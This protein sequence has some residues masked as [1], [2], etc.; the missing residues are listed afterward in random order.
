MARGATH[1]SDEARDGCGKRLRRSFPEKR[2]VM[3]TAAE[4]ADPLALL[5]EQNLARIPELV[6]VR[7]G[8]MAASPFCVLPGCRRCHGGRPG[9]HPGDGIEVAAAATPTSQ[10][11]AVRVAGAAASFRNL[12]DSMRHS[13]LLGM[14]RQAWRPAGTNRRP[15]KR[16][17]RALQRG[18][19]P[20]SGANLPGAYD[21][22]AQLGAL[23][24]YYQP[25]RH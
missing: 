19:S 7:M 1:V 6:P 24:V 4:R 2:T 23:D 11:W 3:E 17:D 9:L 20:G 13:R 8:R 22:L 21:Q 5:D 14:G 25:G 15:A 16:V 18:G 12:N 10:L